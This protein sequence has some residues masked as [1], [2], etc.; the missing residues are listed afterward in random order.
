MS[1]RSKWIWGALSLLLVT[2][3]AGCASQTAYF[4]PARST[5]TTTTTSGYHAAYYL[6]EFDRNID[7]TVEVW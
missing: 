4:H 6:I 1:T 5:E 3:G 2:V 7:G